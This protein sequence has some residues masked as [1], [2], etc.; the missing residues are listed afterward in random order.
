MGMMNGKKI[1]SYLKHLATV[2][3][4]LKGTPLEV[5]ICGGAAINLLGFI[6]R[7]TKDIDIVS[8]EILPETFREAVKIT[9]DYFGLKS[10]WINQG[11]IDLLRMGLPEGF[12]ARCAKLDFQST[13]IFC[14]ASR[15][16][17]IHFKVYAAA[18][19]IC[20]T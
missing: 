6:Q 7:V 12:H 14:I 20:K 19:I 17:Q 1:T 18:V 9:A 3:N 4:S 10:D 13:L 8:P 5:S 11:P 15:L 2:Y 16:D